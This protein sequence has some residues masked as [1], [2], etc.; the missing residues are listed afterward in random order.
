MLVTEQQILVN[1]FKFEAHAVL[2]KLFTLLY[3]VLNI[4]N[5]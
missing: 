5:W 2:F 4:S 3:N 1:Y